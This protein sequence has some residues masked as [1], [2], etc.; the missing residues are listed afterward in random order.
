MNQGHPQVEQATPAHKIQMKLYAITQESKK[1]KEKCIFFTSTAGN[2]NDVVT[3]SM[4]TI[5]Y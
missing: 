3:V 1:W 4:F 5:F 2:D